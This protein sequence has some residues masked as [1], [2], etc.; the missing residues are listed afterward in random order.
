MTGDE[1]AEIIEAFKKPFHQ[2]MIKLSQDLYEKHIPAIFKDA[3][4]FQDWMKGGGGSMAVRRRRSFQRAPQQVTPQELDRQLEI[5]YLR[6][7]D[8]ICLGVRETLPNLDKT[9]FFVGNIS[10][11]DRFR[12]DCERNYLNRWEVRF[13][14]RNFKG[15]EGIDVKTAKLWLDQERGVLCAKFPYD[16]K[17]IKE[18]KDRIPTGKKMWKSETKIWEFSVE[19]IKEIVSILEA[20]FEKV[21]DL[22]KEEQQVVLQGGVKDLLLN[23][24]D[25]DDKKA[26]YRILAR[27][28]HPDAGGD[29]KKMSEIN[30]I[31]QVNG[32][33]R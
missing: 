23:L 31:F 26:I 33:K 24:L 6:Y 30:A 8:E 32:E 5:L 11:E 14:P 16:E 15:W 29:G 20:H 3:A 7:V 10:A 2:E 17:V 25:A 1:I 9:E 28:Y 4:P 19:T 12:D 27:K 13:V 21:I 22:T 18:I